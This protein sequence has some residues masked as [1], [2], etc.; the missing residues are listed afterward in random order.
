VRFR[1]KVHFGSTCHRRAG[2][3]HP[4]E[5]TATCHIALCVIINSNGFT[6]CLGP[7]CRQTGATPY[8]C[9]VSLPH[10]GYTTYARRA[11]VSPPYWSARPTAN[12]NC[13]PI[14]VLATFSARRPRRSLRLIS[15]R[16]R[17]IRR[18][19]FSLLPQKSLPNVSMFGKLLWNNVCGG[20][21]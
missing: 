17:N 4:P 8:D 13:H 3:P 6:A 5:K 16:R 14:L 20:E 10:R 19:S 2:G 7:A 1:I 21:M 9:C 12:R 18:F 11:G 15:W